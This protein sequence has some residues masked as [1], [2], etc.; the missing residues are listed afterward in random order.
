[1]NE[2]GQ[3]RLLRL[4]LCERSTLTQRGQQELAEIEADSLAMVELAMAFEE[5]YGLRS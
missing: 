3:S 1:M 5:K 4:F 2:N